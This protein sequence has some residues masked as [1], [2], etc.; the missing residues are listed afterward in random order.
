MAWKH[1]DI[2][3]KGKTERDHKSGSWARSIQNKIT[4]A[5]YQ[6]DTSKSKSFSEI[7][8]TCNGKK[9]R[10]SAASSI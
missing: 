9:N 7:A 4:R 5:E 6:K 10:F 1:V 8:H 2:C 3:R